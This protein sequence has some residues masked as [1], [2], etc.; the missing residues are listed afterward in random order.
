MSSYPWE[1]AYLA[2]VAAHPE[3]TPTEANIPLTFEEYSSLFTLSPSEPMGSRLDE[4]AVHFRKTV[5]Y[6]LFE[7]EKSQESR[8][9][10]REQLNRLAG[11]SEDVLSFDLW[12]PDNGDAIFHAGLWN[13]VSGALQAYATYMLIELCA[14]VWFAHCGEGAPYGP[15]PR[16]H[17]FTGNPRF[18]VPGTGPLPPPSPSSPQSS[19]E[20]YIPDPRVEAP[21]SRI[22]TAEDAE[23]GCPICRFIPVVEGETMLTVLPCKG[24]KEHFFHAICI[25]PW[26]VERKKQECVYRCE[27]RKNPPPSLPATTVTEPIAVGPGEEHSDYDFTF[28]F[29][30]EPYASDEE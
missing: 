17:S 26:F 4:F 13:P 7:V 5:L 19:A 8:D 22:A 18:M 24:S 30:D 25:D 14:N 28:T 27:Q 11:L 2:R 3:V 6:A 29:P 21:S 15:A 12:C 20:G 1:L 10:L 16:H 23:D 9:K